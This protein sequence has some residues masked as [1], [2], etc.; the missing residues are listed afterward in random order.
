MIAVFV[1]VVEFN[2]HKDQILLLLKVSYADIRN[3][4]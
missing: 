3:I 2:D 4:I 1:C